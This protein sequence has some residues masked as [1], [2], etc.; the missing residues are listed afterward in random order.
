M[1]S[2]NLLVNC[3]HNDNTAGIAH[4]ALKSQREGKSRQIVN[5]LKLIP[6]ARQNRRMHRSSRTLSFCV[7]LFHLKTSL[8]VNKTFSIC[9]Y[10]MTFLRSPD[11]QGHDL[12]KSYLSVDC[13]YS[14]NF[15]CVEL[16]T[17]RG[18]KTFKL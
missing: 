11:L 3:S 17:T 9:L 4:P 1:N 13:Q 18:R 5:Y 6:Q 10:P 14:L 8:F 15:V 12:L 16:L 7:L 2:T